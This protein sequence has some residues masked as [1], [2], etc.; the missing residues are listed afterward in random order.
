M[1]CEQVSTEWKRLSSSEVVWEEIARVYEESTGGLYHYRF[2][3][4]PLWKE[5]LKET[6]LYHKKSKDRWIA[7]LKNVHY[8]FKE[9]KYCKE[10]ERYNDMKFY[11]KFHNK[12]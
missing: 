4:C 11:D 12:F 1:K 8:S 10:K 6:Y 3:I 2:L 5:I 9:I 7:R